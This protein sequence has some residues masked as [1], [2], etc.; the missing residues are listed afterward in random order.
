V[1]LLPR[2]LLNAAGWILGWLAGSVLRIRRAHV[3]ASMRAAGIAGVARQARGMYRALG[4]SAMEFLWLAVAGRGALAGVRIDEESRER[5]RDVVTRGRGVVV[6][7]SHTG[8]WDLA[9]CAMARQGELLVVT[10]RLRIGWLDRFWQT[11]RARQGVT[12]VDAPGA[13][14]RAR[15]VLGRG[16]AVA[17]MIDQVPTSARHASTVDF[18]G[19]PAHVDRAPAALAASAR[20][21][22]VVAAA[23]RGPRGEQ[24]LYVLDVLEPPQRPARAWVDAATAVATRALDRFVRDH[25]TEWLWLHRRWKRLDRGSRA[26][27]LVAPCTTPSPSPG[28]S[29]RAA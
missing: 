26:A 22:L 6:A 24:V 15:E 19:R 5:W 12:L 8:N 7:A 2:F 13:M 9:A 25:P 23:A 4:V 1:A 17:L 29:S 11:T 20:A 3:E 28:A 14:R 27:M 16:G 21:P 18:L 10:K